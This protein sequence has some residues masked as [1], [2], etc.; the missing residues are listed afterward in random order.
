MKRIRAALVVGLGVGSTLGAPCLA[1]ADQVDSRYGFTP[2]VGG[3]FAV[4]THASPL[5]GFVGMTALGGEILG[6]V[7]PWGGFLRAEYLS[8][9]QDGRWTGL[10]FVLG[11]SRRLFG[12][13]THLSLLARGGIAYQHWHGASGGCDVI[14]FVPNSCISQAAPATPGTVTTP[15][16]ITDYS[17]NAMGIL[18]GARLELPIK[19]V[20]LAIDAS[21]I[22]VIDVDTTSPTAVLGF[23]LDLV[24]GFRD[25]RVN[26]TAPEPQQPIGPR[27]KRGT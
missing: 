6:E 26:T 25:R 12:R 18:A 13:A 14:L 2:T 8:T 23:R 21:F 17:G 3:G 7:P 16:N 1:R 9:G 22:P 20:Y 15:V 24:L 19:P 5:P 11:G 4:V 27:F 10:S